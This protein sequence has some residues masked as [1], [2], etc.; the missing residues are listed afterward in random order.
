[1]LELTIE[2]NKT[3]ICSGTV[4]KQLLEKNMIVENTDCVIPSPDGKNVQY[5]KKKMVKPLAYVSLLFS[6]H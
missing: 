3:I 4:I 2:K 6:N 5:E 1:M